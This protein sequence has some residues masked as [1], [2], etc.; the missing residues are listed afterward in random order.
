MGLWHVGD[1]GPPEHWLENQPD[2]E[3]CDGKGFI[4]GNNEELG[5]ATCVDCEACH[6]K[7]KLPYKE[8]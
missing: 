6:G 2:C 7:G 8:E 3:W 1:L 5:G 4:E